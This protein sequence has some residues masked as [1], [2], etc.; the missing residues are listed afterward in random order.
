MNVFITN[1]LPVTQ[2][3]LV[4]AHDAGYSEGYAQYPVDHPPTAAFQAGFSVINNG[5]ITG[6]VVTSYDSSNNVLSTDTLPPSSAT[7]TKH[8]ADWPAGAVKYTMTVPDGFRF[9]TVGLSGDGV[10]NTANVPT[11]DVHIQDFTK[12]ILQGLGMF[13]TAVVLPNFSP[14]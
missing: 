4:A 5:N 3:D 8:I 12:L 9:V 13:M 6:I 7:W 2:Q 10:Y 1:P 11:A 14:S